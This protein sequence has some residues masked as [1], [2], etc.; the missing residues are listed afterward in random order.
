MHTETVAHSIWDFI[1]KVASSQNTS[2]PKTK[3]LI[4]IELWKNIW[5]E[6]QKNL[7]KY[8]CIIIGWDYALLH[9]LNIM[10]KK[11]GKMDCIISMQDAL[12]LWPMMLI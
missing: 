4:K 2:Q 3:L 9:A 10:D 6:T 5:E 7:K 1:R 8:I 12:E 11:G